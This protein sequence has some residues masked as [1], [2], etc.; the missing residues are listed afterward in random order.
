MST[1]NNPRIVLVSLRDQADFGATHHDLLKALQDKAD[2]VTTYTP[3]EVLRELPPVAG[4]RTTALLLTDAALSIAQIPDEDDMLP[5]DDIS[6]LRRFPETWANIIDYVRHGGTVIAMGRFSSF[7]RPND[8]A[9]FFQKAD[10]RW[11]QGIYQR[12]NVALRIGHNAADLSLAALPERYSQKSQFLRG[13]Q[14]EAALYTADGI[15]SETAIAL[16]KV[17]AGKIGYVGDVNAE[18][19]TTKVILAICGLLS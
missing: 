12:L 15:P 8:I 17:G 9:A 7:V 4:K 2:V 5:S 11:T 13:I 6:T 1:S 10:L 3:D 14:P 19:E 18:N 16:A